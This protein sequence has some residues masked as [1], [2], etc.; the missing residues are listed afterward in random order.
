MTVAPLALDASAVTL[1]METNTGSVVSTTSTRKD[2]DTVL[3]LSSV[4]SHVT[5][6]TPLNYVAS[7]RGVQETNGNTPGRSVAVGTV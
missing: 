3:P 5:V 4:A 6:V 1:A 2:S 7:G